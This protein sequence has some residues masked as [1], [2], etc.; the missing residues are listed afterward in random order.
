MLDKFDYV[1][2]VIIWPLL[3]IGVGLLMIFQICHDD[4]PNN[5]QVIEVNGMLLEYQIEQTGSGKSDYHVLISIRGYKA[6]FMD[7]FLNKEQANQKLQ[8]GV[9]VKFHI[10]K[11]DSRLLYSEENIPTWSTTIDGEILQP[12]NTELK[13]QNGFKYFLLPIMGALMVIFGLLIYVREKKRL[14]PT[15]SDQN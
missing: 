8:K 15:L 4:I 12:L 14:S 2:S 6:R 13:Q 9:K 1:I 3:L 5:N 7:S 10:A 11:T